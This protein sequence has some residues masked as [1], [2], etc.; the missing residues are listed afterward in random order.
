MWNESSLANFFSVATQFYECLSKLKGTSSS[1]TPTDKLFQLA[2]ILVLQI[3]LPAIKNISLF[4]FTLANLQIQ[5][6]HKI[7]YILPDLFAFVQTH[8][9]RQMFCIY[10]VS[11]FFKIQANTYLFEVNNRS[12]IKRCEI[13][14]RLTFVVNFKHILHLF[15]VFPL[16]SLN[17]SVFAGKIPN[18]EFHLQC[19]LP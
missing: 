17:M 13:C 11:K 2:N 12:K 9:N 10:L 3:D 18:L 14:S 6:E 19:S 16:L 5:R 8:K 15:L 1:L 4:H 7:R